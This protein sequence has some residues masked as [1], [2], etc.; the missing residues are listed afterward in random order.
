[1]R[2]WILSNADLFSDMSPTPI[3]LT[4]GN[5]GKATG[6]IN[7]GFKRLLAQLLLRDFRDMFSVASH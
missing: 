2:Y 6:K 4:S 3:R 7:E 1:M 5:C